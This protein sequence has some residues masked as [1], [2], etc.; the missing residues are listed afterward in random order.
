MNDAD[1]LR[2]AAGDFVAGDLDDEQARTFARL[3]D[4]DPE[5]QRDVAFWER[6]HAVLPAA[7]RPP[8]SHQG[9]DDS[10]LRIRHRAARED[11]RRARRLA[12][13]GWGLAMAA[14]IALA[15]LA[16]RDGGGEDEHDRTLVAYAEDGSAL[17]LPAAQFRQ[18]LDADYRQRLATRQMRADD[19][20]PEV[21]VSQRPWLGVWTRPVHLKGL[22]RE[23]GLRVLRL[24]ADTPAARA[25]VRAGDVLLEFANCPMIS[26]YCIRDALQEGSL[27]PGDRAT[28]HYWRPS[29]GE[30]FQR[31]VVLGACHE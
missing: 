16:L 29:S 6:M 22:P 2:H 25:G 26:R 21:D 30:I 28:M 9:G 31:E 20:E 15:V 10:I 13:C 12:W 24:A 8:S 11:A 1:E 18:H 14:G 5:V 23:H 4:E 17:L 27:R 3:R 19:G 7:G